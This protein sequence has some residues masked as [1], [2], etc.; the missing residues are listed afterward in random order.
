MKVSIVVVAF[1]LTLI[2]LNS[3]WSTPGPDSAHVDSGEK[4]ANAEQLIDL[5]DRALGRTIQAAR[6]STDKKLAHDSPDAKPFWQSLK[7]MNESLDKA[8]RGLLLQD[9]TLFSSLHD[10]QAAAEAARITY[11]RSGAK[12]SGV[13]E[14]LSKMVQATS[15]L[16]ENFGLAAGL[17]KENR[18]LNEQEKT[19]LSNFKKQQQQLENK[20]KELEIKQ[21]VDQKEISRLKQQTKRIRNAKYTSADLAGAIFASHLIS[22][23]LW[24]NHWYWGGWWWGWGPGFFVGWIDLSYSCVDYVLYDWATTEI[25]IDIISYNLDVEL[26]AAELAITDAF[27]EESV[28]EIA[29][30]EAAALIQEEVIAETAAVAVEEAVEQEAVRAIEQEAARAMEQEAIRAAEQEAMRAIEQE[31]IRAAEREAMRAIEQEAI[32]AAE[33][34]AMRAVEDEFVRQLMDLG[35]GLDDW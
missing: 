11:A 8:S 3:S 31:A 35:S 21:D 24:G 17:Q 6:N 18:P 25:A 5:A 15:L 32:R 9:K 22:G 26:S 10:C 30:A 20:I 27:I 16:N 14:A 4:S 2:P 33:R 28:I 13:E 23:I 1:L 19:L 7:T 12:D 29:E 34:E